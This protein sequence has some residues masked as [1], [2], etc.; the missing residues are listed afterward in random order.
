MDFTDAHSV[1]AGKAITWTI[2]EV[3]G[4]NFDVFP[5]NYQATQILH[6]PDAY[7]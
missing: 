5:S 1:F 6:R 3:G 4:L 7:M 2:T